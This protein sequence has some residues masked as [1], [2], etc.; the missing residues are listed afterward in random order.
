M[1]GGNVA[2]NL[3]FWLLIA[4]LLIVGLLLFRVIQP[5]LLTIFV[6]VILAVLFEP[7]HHW[8]TNRIGGHDRIAA[9]LTTLIVLLAVLLP[10]GLPCRWLVGR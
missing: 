7:T 2:R 10:L 8:I 4:L 3:S 1:A 5:F 6:S 9:L